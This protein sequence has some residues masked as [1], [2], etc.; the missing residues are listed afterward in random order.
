MG[1]SLYSHQESGTVVRFDPMPDAAHGDMFQL[2]L[3]DGRV[4]QCQVLTQYATYF[5]VMDGPRVE[6]RH[7]RRPTPTTR[8]FL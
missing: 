8:A 2:T 6:R 4:L 1:Y 7:Q 5:V 3:E